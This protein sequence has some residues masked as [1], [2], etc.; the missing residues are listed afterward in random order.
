M[1]S[2]LAPRAIVFSTHPRSPLE[3]H[4]F[5]TSLDYI[6]PKS[7]N[8]PPPPLSQGLS[9]TLPLPNTMDFKPSFLPINLSRSRLSALPK[10]LI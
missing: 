3:P 7:S 6:P 5:L 10:P 9:Q 2:P 4:P 8:P 1:V